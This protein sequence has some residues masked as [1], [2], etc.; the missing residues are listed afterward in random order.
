MNRTT[1]LIFH[2]HFWWYIIVCGRFINIH[3]TNDGFNIFVIH[4]I[5]TK[6]LINLDVFIDLDNTGVGF[7]V[8]DNDRNLFIVIIS[9]YVFSKISRNTKVSHCVGKKV[10]EVLASFSSLDMMSSFSTRTIF[11]CPMRISEKTGYIV[12]QN[13]L[14]SVIEVLSRLL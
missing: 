10:L 4:F 12:F 3:F 13:F 6:A 14:L 8:I 5:K 2:Q 1:I 9:N 7:K 11:C